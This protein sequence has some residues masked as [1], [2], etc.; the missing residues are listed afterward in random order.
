MEGKGREAGNLVKTQYT[1]I[2][3]NGWGL[4]GILYPPSPVCCDGKSRIT[5]RRSLSTP[6]P[7]PVHCHR[8]LETIF[9]SSPHRLPPPPT[10]RGGFR[11]MQAKMRKI[12]IINNIFCNKSKVTAK[13]KHSQSYCS[14]NFL[15]LT[16]NIKF[17]L[18]L[19]WYE[20]IKFLVYIFILLTRVGLRATS[21][22]QFLPI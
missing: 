22:L 13:L 21:N 18:T 19:V 20:I 7:R 17:K 14:Y 9:Q 2:Y 1:Y 16:L 11:W 12:K 5:P 4:E 10:I 15:W 8:Q 3:Y 6:A